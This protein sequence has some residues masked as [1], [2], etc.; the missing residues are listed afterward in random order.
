MLVQ[1]PSCA[2]VTPGEGWHYPKRAIN[3]VPMPKFPLPISAVAADMP[4]EIR[5]QL[6]STRAEPPEGDGWL[7]EMKHDG[8]RLAAIVPHA[9]LGTAQ[10]GHS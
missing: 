3:L 8:H 5:F 1:L 6:S 4:R 7:H 9:A 10:D 2:D